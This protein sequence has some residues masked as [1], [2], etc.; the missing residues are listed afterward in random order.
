MHC[1]RVIMGMTAAFLS[2]SGAVSS[3]QDDAGDKKTSAASDQPVEPT[4]LVRPEN[5]HALMGKDVRSS[6]DERMGPIV[7]ILVDNAGAPSAAV[8]DFGGFLGVGSRKI[9]VDWKALRFTPYENYERITSNLTRD[10][11]KAAPEFKEGQPIF[12]VGVSETATRP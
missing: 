6:S 3:A 12:I 5:I 10:E 9:A 8:I 1:S 4:G 7:N 2:L 11:V